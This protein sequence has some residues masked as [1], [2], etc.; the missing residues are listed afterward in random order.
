MGWT[1]N[2]HGVEASGYFQVRLGAPLQDKGKRTGP[3]R[4]GK[5]DGRE[6]NGFR[7]PTFGLGLVQVGR[8]EMKNEGI[9]RGPALDGKNLPDGFY[10]G[11]QPP[12]PVDRLRWKGHQ[13]TLA[14]KLGSLGK[15]GWVGG[16][17]PGFHPS[18][19]WKIEPREMR[20]VF[21]D[22]GEVEIA[23]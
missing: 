10:P 1:A 5:L 6:R 3:K 18:K 20:D 9:G 17:N 7:H 2:R 21:L 15:A 19:I 8:W 22:F 11:S 14:E 16:E 23:R 12:K 4:F 13:T